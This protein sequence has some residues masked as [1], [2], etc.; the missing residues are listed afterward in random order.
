ME[1]STNPQPSRARRIR[2]WLR[3]ELLPTLALLLLLGTA[4]ASFANH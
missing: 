1:A 3:R 2:L 4:R